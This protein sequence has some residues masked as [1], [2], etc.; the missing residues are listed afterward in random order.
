MGWAFA[1]VNGKLAEIFFEK[2]KNKTMFYGHAY[3]KVE[4]YKSK[5]EKQWI[6]EDTAKNRSSYQKNLYKDKTGNVFP[7]ADFTGTASKLPSSLL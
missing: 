6:K 5:K 1:I 2:K 3:V 7:C 4:E